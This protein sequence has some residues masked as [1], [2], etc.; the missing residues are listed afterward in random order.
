MELNLYKIWSLT[1]IVKD[2]RDIMKLENYIFYVIN[3]VDL[4][5]IDISFKNNTFDIE[6]RLQEA[7]IEQCI[8][9][10]DI[11]DLNISSKDRFKIIR[12]LKLL[13]FIDNYDSIIKYFKNNSKYEWLLEYFDNKKVN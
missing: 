12:E 1:G 8:T 6:I 3:N 7:I 2:N 10:L 13:R 9:D 5:A 11:T 4:S